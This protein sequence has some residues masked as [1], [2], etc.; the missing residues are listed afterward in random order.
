MEILIDDG[1]SLFK[2]FADRLNTAVDATGKVIIPAQF[3]KGYLQRFKFSPG[4]RMMI[5]DYELKEDL[6]IK[7]TTAQV[8][9]EKVIVI[10]H[11]LSVS[12]SENY[13]SGIKTN[14][15]QSVQIFSGN[16]DAEMFFPSMILIKSIVIGIDI[17]YLKELL[18]VD[19]GN[20]IIGTI[21]SHHQSFLFEEQLPAG[22]Q[23]V[24]HEMLTSHIPDKLTNFYY[25]VKAEELLCLLIA[26]LLKRENTTV[27]ALNSND[28]QTIYKI[29]DTIL[30]QLDTPPNLDALATVA[31]F[32]KSKL[33]RLFKQIFGISLFHY[34][35]SFRMQ[36][37]ANLL[38]AHKL[39][40]SEV[41]FRLGFSNMSHFTRLFEEHIGVKPKRWSMES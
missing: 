13:N 41:G 3:G 15:L 5:R 37:A 36:E 27:S 9:T 34:Y 40:V 31:N 2:R 7:R 20:N 16:I 6:L 24:A 25:K 1:V 10:F 11:N 19:Y 8:E 35:Q 30:T 17:D 39:S 33:K 32:S 21:T 29:R 18:K 4:L 28:V 12:E 23:K 22:I 26:E 14:L 38:R